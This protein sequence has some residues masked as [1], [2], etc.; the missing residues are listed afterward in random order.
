MRA[1][2]YTSLVCWATA[3]PVF[4]GRRNLSDL[5]EGEGRVVFICAAHQV[6]AVAPCS[7]VMCQFEHYR[8]HWHWP[9]TGTYNSNI[10]L[11]PPTSRT[12][13]SVFHERKP[14]TWVTHVV[15]TCGASNV[16]RQA[17]VIARSLDSDNP[18]PR[19]TPVCGIAYLFTYS[20]FQALRKQEI[21][22]M[23]SFLSS[24]SPKRGY[25]RGCLAQNRQRGF[26]NF[27]P[28]IHGYVS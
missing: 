16:A 1:V 10:Q 28:K 15:H 2:C 6:L 9:T 8:S 18:L 27:P 21:F 5:L 4:A 24:K 7:S 12:P 26:L 3:Y 23:P 25:F 17:V 14:H 19:Q 11:N 22:G 20:Q 13:A